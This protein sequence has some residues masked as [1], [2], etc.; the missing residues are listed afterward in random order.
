MGIIFAVLD[1][2]A[3]TFAADCEAL[4]N[5]RKQALKYAYV[6]VSLRGCAFERARDVINADVNL[7]EMN[8]VAAVPEYLEQGT[9]TQ[10]FELHSHM[11]IQRSD[12]RLFDTVEA[13]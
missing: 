10:R 2:D 12:V 8:V 5:L 9:P 1:P 11:L 13:L 3:P 7:M 6:L 4:N